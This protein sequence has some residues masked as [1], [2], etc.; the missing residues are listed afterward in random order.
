MTDGILD[1]LQRAVGDGFKVYPGGGTFSADTS[2]WPQLVITDPDGVQTTVE[3]EL[4][5]PGTPTMTVRIEHSP[6][7]T[8]W[9]DI[10]PDDLPPLV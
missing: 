1:A 7:G 3:P 4:P 5:A 9:T 10:G 2:N 8:G 6:E